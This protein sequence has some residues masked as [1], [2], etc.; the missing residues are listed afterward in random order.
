VPHTQANRSDVRLNFASMIKGMYGR[1]ARKINVD[2]SYVSRVAR[3]KRRSDR[4]EASLEREL[5]KI[6]SLANVNHNGAD[7]KRLVAHSK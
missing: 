1:V 4:I 5:R 3:G 6:M 7:R 2:P